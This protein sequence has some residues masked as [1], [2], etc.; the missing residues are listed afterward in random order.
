M[1]TQRVAY[2]GRDDGIVKKGEANDAVI[3]RWGHIVR[4][5][6]QAHPNEDVEVRLCMRF[7][8]PSSTRREMG[9]CEEYVAASERERYVYEVGQY[10][11]QPISQKFGKHGGCEDEERSL[12]R[13]PQG[14]E[15]Q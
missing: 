1:S 5:K 12:S 14:T 8:V 15:R 3:Q 2:L 7:R 11:L 9:Q 13:D 6:R 4:Q 10:P